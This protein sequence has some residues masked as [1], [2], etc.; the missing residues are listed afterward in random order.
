VPGA[1]ETLR[2]AAPSPGASLAPALAAHGAK[3]SAEETE[4]HSPVTSRAPVISPSLGPGGPPLLQGFRI[5]RCSSIKQNMVLSAASTGSHTR[6]KIW[7]KSA[8]LFLNVGFKPGV[9]RPLDFRLL[10][11]YTQ[12]HHDAGFTSLGPARERAPEL[13]FNTQSDTQLDTRLGTP[14]SG[15]FGGLRSDSRSN[16]FEQS[17]RN[18]GLHC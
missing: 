6:G 8:I 1:W 7:G 4:R 12:F 14:C 16:I 11:A 17:R 5:K 10:F 3:S 9:N 15:C 18:L 13:Q 2:R